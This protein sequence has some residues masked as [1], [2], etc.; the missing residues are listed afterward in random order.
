MWKSLC[1]DLFSIAMLSVCVL[2]FL[3]FFRKEK[4]FTFYFW[5]VLAFGFGFAFLG[6]APEK[7]L[8]AVALGLVL[9]VPS[10]CLMVWRLRRAFQGQQPMTGVE[11]PMMPNVPSAHSDFT[12]YWTDSGQNYHF[13]SKCPSLARSKHIRSGTVKEALRAGKKGLCDKCKR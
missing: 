6:V 3:S 13:Y 4:Q 2:G 9:I 8:V 11:T 1:F 5:C 10:I 12:V 7:G